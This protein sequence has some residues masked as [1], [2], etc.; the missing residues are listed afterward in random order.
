MSV[1]ANNPLHGITLEFILLQLKAHYGFR[2]LGQLIPI[3]CFL[4][5]PSIKSSLT[6]LRKTDWA[7]AKVEQLYLD[8]TFDEGEFQKVKLAFIASKTKGK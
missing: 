6:F 5:D 7:K 3:R 1:Q 4:I 2:R 8:S